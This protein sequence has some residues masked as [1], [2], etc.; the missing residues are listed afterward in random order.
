[1]EEYIAKNDIVNIDSIVITRLIGIY[2]NDI[3]QNLDFT[4]ETSNSR[5]E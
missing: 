2:Y 5:R 4:W 1:M 3:L